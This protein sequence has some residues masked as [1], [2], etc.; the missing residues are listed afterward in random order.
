MCLIKCNALK[1]SLWF[2]RYRSDAAANNFKFKFEVLGEIDTEIT[3]RFGVIDDGCSRSSRQS[4]NT[5]I[6][7][8]H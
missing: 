4:V 2:F 7:V 6:V 5:D 1:I 3:V 8:I